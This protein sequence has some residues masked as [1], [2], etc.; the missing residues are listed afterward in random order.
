[1]PKLSGGGGDI[2]DWLSAQLRARGDPAKVL[3]SL[4]YAAQLLAHSSTCLRT[5]SLVAYAYVIPVL[6]W[7]AASRFWNRQDLAT[8]LTM[9]L[10]MSR[11]ALDLWHDSDDP[12]ATYMKSVASWCGTLYKGV[13]IP[14]WDVALRSCREPARWISQAI[15]WR[16][17]SYETQNTAKRHEPSSGDSPI[18][19]DAAWLVVEALGRSCVTTIASKMA[20]AMWWLRTRTS[21][22]I[23]NKRV[24]MHAL[25][26]IRMYRF[27]AGDGWLSRR[28]APRRAYDVVFSSCGQ[29]CASASFTSRIAHVDTA[30]VGQTKS[31]TT[32]H[33]S[34]FV[35][36]RR[37]PAS[38]LRRS[39]ISHKSL[40]AAGHDAF[41][42]GIG[43]AATGAPSRMR[44]PSF[45]RRAAFGSAFAS[46]EER[47]D[48]GG[49]S[50][51]RCGPE[52]KEESGEETDGD[53]ARSPL[54]VRR[55]PPGFATSASLVSDVFP[56]SAQPQ[57]RPDGARTRRRD[58]VSREIYSHRVGRIIAS[59]SL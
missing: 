26:L 42:G 27:I 13:N 57:P 54:S 34:T 35:A 7:C 6:S 51:G 15:Q 18:R 41:I 5:D 29:S 45:G 44:V 2:A 9:E 17:A 38:C 39:P 59:R 43:P 3:G 53:S 11:R 30:K 32:Y 21:G 19:T 23:W 16:D 33:E 25:E 49:R 56:Q 22:T 14:R 28:H 46:G 48:P 1:M 10:H 24:H 36:L 47:E 40:R 12:I 20:L 31:K 55:P 37:K 4:S 58:E 8:I 52:D 50:R